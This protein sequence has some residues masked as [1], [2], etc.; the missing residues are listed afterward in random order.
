M[1]NT[2]MRNSV[3]GTFYHY[4]KITVFWDVT[5]CNFVR[6]DRRFGEYLLPPSYNQIPLAK[7]RGSG[8]HSIVSAYIPDSEAY[9]STRAAMYI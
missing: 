8:F 1:D 9:I 6:M 7:V 4:L 2:D 3:L 5:P